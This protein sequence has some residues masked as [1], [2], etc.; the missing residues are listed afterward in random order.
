MRT[1][2]KCGRELPEDAIVCPY[3]SKGKESVLNGIAINDGDEIDREYQEQHKTC[4]RCGRD[5]VTDWEKEHGICVYCNNGDNNNGNNKEKAMNNKKESPLLM[6][7]GVILLVIAFKMISKPSSDIGNTNSSNSITSK[8]GT[9]KTETT[10]FEPDLSDQLVAIGIS[11]KYASADESIFEQCGVDHITGAKKQTEFNDITVYTAEQ[12]K[13]RKLTIMV[14]DNE[15][16]YLGIDGCDLYTYDLGCIQTADNVD[17]PPTISSNMKSSLISA[18]KSYIKGTVKYP[19][20][21]Y[22][23]DAHWEFDK[24]DDFYF[25]YGYYRYNDALG[26]EQRDT[27][28]MDITKTESNEYAL[29]RAQTLSEMI[30]EAYSLFGEQYGEAAEKYLSTVY[31]VYG[32]REKGIFLYRELMIGRSLINQGV[33]QVNSYVAAK[34]LT[35]M[36]YT[37]SKD[38][39]FT[40]QNIFER[41]MKVIDYNEYGAMQA[42]GK[43]VSDI[44]LSY[45]AKSLGITTSLDNMSSEERA[46]LLTTAL[47]K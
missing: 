25:G 5:L 39:G 27:I 15:L 17:E 26:N 3:C 8:P 40:S 6:L 9:A 21:L 2:K 10:E 22:F 33:S 38:I 20:T 4:L 42:I 32:E 37:F 41:L 19:S 43:P 13:N 46:L 24:L 11:E 16:F 29:N 47:L 31:N 35:Q 28:Y 44:E 45:Y 12:G 7:L 14:R 30:S 36:C 18:S 34:S 23:Y 1:C